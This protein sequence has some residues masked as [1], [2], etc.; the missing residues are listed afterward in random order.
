MKDWPEGT[1]PELVE[2]WN[3]SYNRA[4]KAGREGR[5][6]WK[7]GKWGIASRIQELIGYVEE[8]RVVRPV[9]FDTGLAALN[10][11]L[12]SGLPVG[13]TEVFGAESVGKS[14]LA[15][16][17]IGAAQVAGMR[18]VL[19]ATQRPPVDLMERL[20]V[21]TKELCLLRAC[22]LE[23]AVVALLDEFVPR[24][25]RL[26][27]VVDTATAL[28]PWSDDP[29]GWTWHM[30]GFLGG[31]ANNM[32]PCSAALIINE[33]RARRSAAPTKMFAGGTDSA[34][35]RVASMFPTRLELVRDRVSE[36]EYDLVVH[37]VANPNRP[38]RQYVSLPACKGGGVDAV[39]SLVETAVNMGVVEQRGTW[40]YFE[41]WGLG[42]GA[43][44]A[45]EFLRLD[46]QESV[47]D[48]L[49]V[50]VQ[51]LISGAG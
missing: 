37:A 35:Q 22:Y 19:C 48:R 1:P 21:N 17:L 31:L 47:L 41:D 10:A 49:Y 14:S 15:Y 50:K 36:E 2:M 38:P 18:A 3:D 34:A 12:G 46:E 16:Q 29:G 43:R 25:G 13:I 30:E 28:R 26:F 6:E 39:R 8:R 45:S 27:L 11:L 33:V 51:E 4:T 5:K 20:G 32:S 7:E 24:E 42:Q 23:D 40:L 9:A 44:Q